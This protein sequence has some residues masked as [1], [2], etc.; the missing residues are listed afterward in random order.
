MSFIP[1]IPLGTNTASFRIRRR[2][3]AASAV[4]VVA[5]TAATVSLGPLG[6][7]AQPPAE[8]VSMLSAAAVA[9]VTGP[10]GADYATDTFG[11]PWDFSNTDD[12]IL[13]FSGTVKTSGLGMAN[14]QVHARLTANSA[15][16]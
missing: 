2:R 7:A 1:R 16:L 11:D 10:S 3:S 15:Y 14:G 5:L 4:L 12:M 6:A 13:N 8:S 9:T